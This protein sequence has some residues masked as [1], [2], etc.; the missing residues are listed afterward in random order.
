MTQKELENKVI[1]L[2]EQVAIFSIVPSTA[3]QEFMQIINQHVA[4]VIGRDEKPLSE[5]TNYE[6]NQAR[7]QRN[8]LRTEM[9]KRAGLEK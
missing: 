5:K 3:R 8:Y 1:E 6:A 2:Y 4:E 7:Q 9:R